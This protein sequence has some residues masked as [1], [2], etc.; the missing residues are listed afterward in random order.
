M[1][2]CLKIANL[3]D[4]I[5]WKKEAIE[6]Y[7][8]AKNNTKS[9]DEGNKPAIGFPLKD[10]R[11]YAAASL[12]RLTEDVAYHDQ[13]IK[14]LSAVTSSTNLSEE[15]RWAPYIYISMPESIAKNAELYTRLSGAVFSTGDNVVS[16]V[17]NRACRFGGDYSMPMLIGQA[18]TPR[19]FEAIMAYKLAKSS[20][21]AK[22]NKYLSAIYTT[23]DY[24]LGCN[25]LNTTWITG[26]GKRQ[27]ERVFHM[28]SWYN[29]KL[30]MAPGITPYGPWRVES[31]ST[32]QG[33]WDMKWPYKTLY[34]ADINNWPG[35]ERWFS[36]YTC[37]M[38]AEYTIHQNTILNA[39]VF[40]FLCN[41]ASA[42]FTPNRRPTITFKTPAENSEYKQFD[43]VPFTVNAS[44]PDGSNNIWKVVYYNGWHKVGE[45]YTAPYSFDWENTSSGI[46]KLTARIYDKFGVIGRTDTIL[47]NAKPNS[48]ESSIADKISIS[49]FPNPFE[50]EI[51]FNYS[52]KSEG[53]V[54][55][56]II[57]ISGK[58]IKTL[59]DSKKPAG[60]HSVKWN[61]TNNKEI[62]VKPGIYFTKIMIKDKSNAYSD[63]IKVIYNKLD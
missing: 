61:G 57:D 21:A 59:S 10:I 25:P 35:H 11:A 30:G 23:A 6:S 43:K 39:A 38:N 13:L 50:S 15:A 40:G 3:T 29:G 42:G 62:S 51:T 56:E 20:D 53:R 47:V 31:Y 41:N 22:A 49:A 14:D 45:S 27:P 8:W 60:N 32:G 48:V 44:D 19:V 33:A 58:K 55:I 54:S 12:Y 9:G 18:T 2:Y 63:T 46:L 26:L 24:F 16:S 1:A 52:L 36:N 28:D 37:P 5:D 34:P 7:E 4:D 17:I